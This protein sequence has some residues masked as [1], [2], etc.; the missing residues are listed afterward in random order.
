MSNTRFDVIVIGVGTMGS[1][2]CW[3]LAHRGVRVLGIDRYDVPHTHGAHHGGSRV[4]RKAYFEHP[5]Y[6]PLLHE[7]YRGWDELERDS[8]RTLLHRTGGLYMGRPDSEAIAGSLEAMHTHDLD[9]E[10]LT[11]EQVHERYPMFRLPEDFVGLIEPVTGFVEPEGAVAAMSE[12]ARQSGAE[13][14]YGEPVT[15]W[16]ATSTGVTV[17]TQRDTYHA[18]RLI[19][20]AGAWS[21]VIGNACG[22]LGVDLVVTRQVFGWVTPRRPELFAIGTLPVWLIETGRGGQH[23]GMPMLPGQTSLKIALHHPGTPTDPDR[24]DRTTHPDDEATFRYV[25]RDHIPDADGPMVDM[26][27]CLY[28]NSPDSHFVIDRHP[29][30]A[31]HDRVIIAC[32]FSGHGFKFAPAVG[33]ALADLAADNRTD[34]P[35][36]FLGV[37]RFK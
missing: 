23:Y 7:A 10:E 8:G 14:R 24:V 11:R 27:T 13:L 20:S 16:S 28:T 33:R 30:P 31:A 4:V 19:V 26:K 5:D 29:D 12:L 3:R 22:K 35:I 18:D 21:S 34:L 6:V 17:Q 37:S 9:H 1:A 15:T 32:G 25:L 2:A 36:D